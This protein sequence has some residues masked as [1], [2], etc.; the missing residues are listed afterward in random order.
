MANKLFDLAKKNIKKTDEA[1]ALEALTEAVED[2]QMAFANDL[3][4]AKKAVKIAEKRVAAL[5]AD[6]TATA[7]TIL[8]A[9]RAAKLAK[10][11]VEDIEAIIGRRF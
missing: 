5:D 10:K 3:H 7:S 9:E 4:E 11:N 8:D 2:N 1:K 6:P